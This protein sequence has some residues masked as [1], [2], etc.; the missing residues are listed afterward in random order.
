M[1]EAFGSR[2]L[3]MSRFQAP[4]GNGTLMPKTRAA[5]LS[6]MSKDRKATGICAILFPQ[7]GL[8]DPG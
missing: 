8:T 6:R 7:I 3:L 4:P 1:T 2:S 5:L